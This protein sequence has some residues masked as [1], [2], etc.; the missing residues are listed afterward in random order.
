[1]EDYQC[2]VSN[3]ERVRN[4]LAMYDDYRS[5][6]PNAVLTKV[7][8]EDE[9]ELTIELYEYM[10]PGTVSGSRGQMVLSADI[11]IDGR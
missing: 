10:E 6:H 1:M 8:I 9:N 4:L 2:A 3:L 7:S 11:L 5:K